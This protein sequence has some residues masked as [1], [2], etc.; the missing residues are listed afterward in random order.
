MGA[1]HA[2]RQ[3]LAIIDEQAV[4]VVALDSGEILSAHVIEPEK[5][6]WR[7][8]RRDPGRWPGSQGTG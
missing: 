3:V 4:T 1:A 8:T 2:C 5:G 7:N 6:Y